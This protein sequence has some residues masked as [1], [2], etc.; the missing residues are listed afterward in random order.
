VATTAGKQ[1][2]TERNSTRTAVAY[3]RTSSAANVGPDKDSLARQREAVAAYAKAHGLMIVREFYDA[4]VSGAHPI[5]QRPGFLAMLQYLHSNG[6]RVILLE[7]ASRFARDLAVQLAGHDLLKARGIE[8][9]PV[10]APEHFQDETPTAIMVRQILGAVAQFEKDPK[11]A[12][13][14]VD[15]AWIE[16]QIPSYSQKVCPVSHE[17]LGGEM[18]DPVDYLYGTKLVRF[19][20]K[21]CVRKFE[22]EPDKFLTAQK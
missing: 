18:G 21:S 16:A 22:K 2:E 19:C 9:I 8:L 7:T 3:Y 11:T 20:C 12:M 13:Q 1:A 15:R 14:K 6:A 10:D 4:A 5:D 17:A